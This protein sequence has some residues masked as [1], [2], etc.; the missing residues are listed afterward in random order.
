M[1]QEKKL[2]TYLHKKNFIISAAQFFY[3][4]LSVST[5]Y[6]ISYKD[7]WLMAWFIVEN[8]EKN[9]LQLKL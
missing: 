9:C 1:W 5:K 6:Y 8:G 2:S 3:W 4:D 7:R